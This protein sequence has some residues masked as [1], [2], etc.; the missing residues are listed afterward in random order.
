MTK[1]GDNMKSKVLA[2]KPIKIYRRL[3]SGWSERVKNQSRSHCDVCQQ[4]LW[5]N[6]GGEPYCNGGWNACQPGGAR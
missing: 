1:I 6:P 3:A 4:P 2:A 5:V